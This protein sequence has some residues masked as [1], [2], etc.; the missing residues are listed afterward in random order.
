[1]LAAAFIVSAANRR[2]AAER[3]RNR[4]DRILPKNNSQQLALIPRIALTPP[5]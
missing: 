3:H 4:P 5:S 1:M 2:A